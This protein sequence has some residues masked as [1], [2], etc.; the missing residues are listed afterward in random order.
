MKKK[1]GKG[2]RL[3]KKL[4]QKE[5]EDFKMP[6]ITKEE[7]VEKRDTRTECGHICKPPKI[8]VDM[9]RPSE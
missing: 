5:T 4:S 1:R 8:E 2:K 9:E 3:C 6:E 7:L